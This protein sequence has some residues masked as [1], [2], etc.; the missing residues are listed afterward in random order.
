[1]T[2]E[3]K[4]RIIENLKPLKRA[5][6]YATTLYEGVIH[7]LLQIGRKRKNIARVVCAW[8]GKVLNANYKTSN[9]QD[10]HGICSDCKDK[11]LSDFVRECDRQ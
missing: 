10:S 1:M 11:V 8:C 6:T 7:P 5:E 9:G 3:T 4:I 2:P